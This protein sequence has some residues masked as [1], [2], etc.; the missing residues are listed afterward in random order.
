MGT[1][2]WAEPAARPRLVLDALDR[3]EWRS[4]RQVRLRLG[5]GDHPADKR[6]VTRALRR[7][8]R[9]GAAK[10]NMVH[11]IDGVPV[12]RRSEEL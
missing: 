3:E 4:A 5:L 9:E 6:R 11:R 10:R 12:Y 1:V 2:T 8:M 7:L